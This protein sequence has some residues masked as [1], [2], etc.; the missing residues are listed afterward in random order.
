MKKS[1]LYLSLVVEVREPKTQSENR[2]CCAT[3]LASKQSSV[4]QN[5]DMHKKENRPQPDGHDRYNLTNETMPT[6]LSS[7][8]RKRT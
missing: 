2:G 4:K 6:R 1:R 3:T 8:V 5:F 7:S